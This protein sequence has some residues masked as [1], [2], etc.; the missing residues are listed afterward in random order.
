VSKALAL[1]WPTLLVVSA[2]CGLAASLVL[3]LPLIAACAAVLAVLGVALGVDGPAR[4]AGLAVV[5]ALLG[6]AWGSLRMEALR[7]SVLHTRIGQTGQATLV[8]VA[9]ARRSQWSTRV[10]AELR[11]FQH[12]PLR[13]RVL[14][15]LPVGRSPPR[16]TILDATVDLE[17]PRPAEDGFDEHAWLARQGIHVVVDASSWRQIGRRGGIL[18]LGDRLR[19]RI[20]LAIGRGTSGVRRGI[21]L[22]VVLGE[23][24]GLPDDVQQDFRASGLYHLL[25]VSG[26]NVAFLAAGVLG[27]AWLVRLSRVWRELATLAVIAASSSRSAGNRPLPGL[28][29]RARSCRSRG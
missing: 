25:A 15:V 8:T 1:H 7:G 21:V 22:G 4:V 18:G 29:S 9:P 13:E 11:E 20:E 6:L 12:E 19:D 5:L 24:E 26:Q 10:I 23:D 17:E 14:L 28:V 2:C 3:T 27:L 16:G